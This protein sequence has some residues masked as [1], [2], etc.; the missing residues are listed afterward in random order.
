MTKRTH[1]MSLNQIKEK[2]LDQMYYVHK[3]NI[4]LGDVDLFRPL[5]MMSSSR[6]EL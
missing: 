3:N 1:N 5:E 2:A 4:G 6:I